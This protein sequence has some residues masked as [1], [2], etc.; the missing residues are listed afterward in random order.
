[1]DSTI[2]KSVQRWWWPAVALLG[3]IIVAGGIGAGGETQATAA[4]PAVAQNDGELFSDDFEAGLEK[5]DVSNAEVMTIFDSGDAEHGHVFRL[6]PAE[7][8][9]A[10]LIRGSENWPAYR[11]EGEVLF[12]T[13]EHNYLG[14]IY[15]YA[16]NGRR[17]DLGSLYIKGNGTYI[18]VNPR[19]DWNPARMLYEEYF[20]RLTGDDAIV[21]GEWQRFAAEV[22]GSICHLYVGDMNVPKVTFDYYEG[23]S[24]KAGFKPR[25]VGG[26]VWIDN[27]R[28]VAIDGLTYTGPRRPEG[29][30]YRRD[31][32]VTDW[33]VLGPLT[34]AYLDLE[35]LPA[36]GAVT[37]ME[38]AIDSGS[39]VDDGIERRWEPF[40]ADPRGA[41]LTG[42]VVEFLGSRSVAYFAT[43]ITVPAGA[44]L[45][46]Q[47]STLDDLALWR[48]GIFRGYVNGE[49]FAWHDFGRN[50]EHPPSDWMRLEPGVNHVLVRV[51]GGIYATGG[52]FARVAPA[53][54]A[55][56]ML[57][58]R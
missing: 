7:A 6:A 22:D 18:R 34:R 32:L 11:I 41:V 5:W 56:A 27:I 17:A 23:D 52:F 26:P 13:D 25:V 42:R 30:E 14:W 58:E 20:T 39:I 48:N 54:S 1:M 38:A 28:A 15:N 10:A 12:P 21:I 9:I 53:G 50:P 49:I 36:P 57:S 19:R 55:R 29:I 45:E 47:F 2:D 33:R 37:G 40:P 51:R 3:G 43:T 46:L 35:K 16:E 24:G 31:E 4:T 44:D 8:Q